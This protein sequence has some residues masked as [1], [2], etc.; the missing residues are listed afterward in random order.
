MK[1]TRKKRLSLERTRI[2]MLSD[3]HVGRAAGG[4]T[5]LVSTYELTDTPECSSSITEADTFK[6]Q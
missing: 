1:R 4:I 6:C 5:T 2:R 3:R